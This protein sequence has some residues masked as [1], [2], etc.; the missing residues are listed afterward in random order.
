[1]Y[2]PSEK[3]LWLGIVLWGSAMIP[4][5]IYFFLAPKIFLLLLI[6]VIL[7]VFI[8]WI[9]FKT[10]YTINEKELI[11]QTGPFRSKIPLKSIRKVSRTRNPLSSPALSLDRLDIKFSEGS[12]LISPADAN[13]FINTLKERCPHVDIKLE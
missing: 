1:M 10:G 4:V 12:I 6:G 5:A 11:A 13:T 2:F 9:W 3:D 8:G 7:I